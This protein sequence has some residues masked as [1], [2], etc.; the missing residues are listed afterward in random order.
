MASSG[1]EGFS[2]NKIYTLGVLVLMYPF[3]G[4]LC[5]DRWKGLIS[6]HSVQLLNSRSVVK[7]CG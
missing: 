2:L 3:V 4:H 6:R 1:R 5:G 7:V